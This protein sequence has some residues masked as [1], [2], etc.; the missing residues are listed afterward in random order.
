MA[1]KKRVKKDEKAEPSVTYFRCPHC[2]ETWDLY[3]K[4]VTVS[5]KVCPR[6]GKP[7]VQKGS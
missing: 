2:G 6:C 7:G 5:S 4:N 1:W 3:S